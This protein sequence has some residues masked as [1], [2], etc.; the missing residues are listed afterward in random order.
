MSEPDIELASLT[1]RQNKERLFTVRCLSS[2]SYATATPVFS[3]KRHQ[4]D[5]GVLSIAG[6]DSVYV[7]DAETVHITLAVN[8]LSRVG[9]FEDLQAFTDGKQRKQTPQVLTAIHGKQ[10]KQT[11]QV[12][13]AI[14]DKQRKQT[15]QV[16]TAIH[17]KQRKQTPQ[18]L[19]MINGKQRKQTPQVLTAINVVLTWCNALVEDMPTKIR[20][21]RHTPTKFYGSRPLDSL[22]GLGLNARGQ[23]VE[24]GESGASMEQVITGGEV[25]L[26]MP[27][28]RHM[29]DCDPNSVDVGIVGSTSFQMLANSPFLSDIASGQWDLI[30]QLPMQSI[31]DHMSVSRQKISGSQIR[32]NR[33]PSSP[34]LSIPATTPANCPGMLLINPDTFPP[35]GE[36]HTEYHRRMARMVVAARGATGRRDLV[37]WVSQLRGSTSA[38]R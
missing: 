7:L 5:R 20:N 1:H 10:R 15:P 26:L 11:P 9:L 36:G 2:A 17:G 25:V 35:S 30:L 4:D 33:T 23:Q 29:A 12:L 19:T 37:A 28:G 14:H 24:R 32:R 34:S 22:N 6:I 38:K 27:H 16:L 31:P 21:F 13:T 3:N 18:V 8:A